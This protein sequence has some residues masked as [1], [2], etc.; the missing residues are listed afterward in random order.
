MSASM[1]AS[2]TPLATIRA[3]RK[4]GCAI[5]IVERAGR[6]PHRY[7]VLLRRYRSLREW[8]AF[9]LHPWRACGAWLRAILIAHLTSRLGSRG[10]HPFDTRSPWASSK[11]H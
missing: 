8:T 1:S 7:R 10:V 5:V 3:H 9:G 11:L 4:A 2:E 6:P